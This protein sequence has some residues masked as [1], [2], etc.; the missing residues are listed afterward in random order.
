MTSVCFVAKT[1]Y[2][3]TGSKDR[4]IKYWD[5]DRFAAINTLGGGVASGAS[6]R[7]EVWALAA[8][9]DGT[10]L[11]SGGGDRSLRVWRRTDEQVFP[12]EEREAE[13]EAAWGK[14]FKEADGEGVLAGEDEVGAIG[15]DGMALE[16]GEGEEGG[17]VEVGGGKRRGAGGGSGKPVTM[18]FVG[19]GVMVAAGAGAGASSTGVVA[20]ASGEASRSGERLMDA[21]ELAGK[22]VEAWERYVDECN[23]AASLGHSVDGVAPPPQNPALLGNVTP[24]QYVLKAL[25]AIAPGDIDQVLLLL[26]FPAALTLLRFL[27]LGMK[28]GLALE[29]CARCT[30]LLLRCHGPQLTA[31]GRHAPFLG[32]LKQSSLASLQGAR[33]TIGVNIAGL[34]AWD[35]ELEGETVAALR[36][37]ETLSGEVEGGEEGKAGKAGGGKAAKG[38][39]K[40]TVSIGKRRKVTLL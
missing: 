33:D 23:M 35:K 36:F 29:L 20:A 26:P 1:H 16:D 6:H 28:R 21:L 15:Q 11:V 10:Y 34:K 17:E 4:V 14:E 2:F 30:L 38:G 3:F 9:P 25:K 31:S 8:S 39:A 18:G 5:G 22:E 32:L 37:G 24:G 7:G 40:N 27:A 13:L 12:E 19:A